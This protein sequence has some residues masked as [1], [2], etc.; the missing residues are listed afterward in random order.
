M[1]KFDNTHAPHSTTEDE[2]KTAPF[3]DEDG[4]CWVCTGPV[5]ERHCKIVCPRCGFTRD[6]SDP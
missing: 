1:S 2:D 4:T 5:I 6:C 3:N